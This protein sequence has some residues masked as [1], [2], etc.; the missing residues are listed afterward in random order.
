MCSDYDGTFNYQGVDERKREAVRRW[1]SAG[2]AFGFVSGRALGT[3]KR[4][5]LHDGVIC[6]FAVAN[7]GAVIADGNCE[8]PDEIRCSGE[9][10]GDLVRAMFELGCPWAC[11]SATPGCTVHRIPP[12]KPGPEDRTAEWAAAN[13]DGFT[14]VSTVL[15]SESESARV[16]AALAGRFGKWVNPLQNGICID[17]VPAG[18][19]KAAGIRRLAARLGVSRDR[20]IAVGD[21]VNDRAMI[22]A[23]RSYA[24]ENAVP[25]IRDLAD[26]V[27]A[28]V[29]ELIDRELGDD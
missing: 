15:P 23:F 27:V 13:L 17:I 18:V 2:N 5:M 3:L 1:R 6:D 29:V 8:N 22:A 14:Q 19:D 16:S 26:F 28:D 21:N 24:V 12:D 9:V 25:G 20:I 4:I 7:N 11:F 10:I